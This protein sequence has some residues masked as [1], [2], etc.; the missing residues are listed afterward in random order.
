MPMARELTIGVL[1]GLGPEATVDFF[2]KVV[3]LTEAAG[4]QDHLHLII[5]NNHKVPNRNA[6]IARIGPS[7]GPALAA[8]ARRLERA[9]AD[10]LVMPCNA[11]HAFTAEIRAATGLPF[12]SII[13]ETLAELSRRAPAMERIGLLTA[14]GCRQARLYEQALEAAALRPV[15]TD[16]PQQARF[17]ELLYAIKAGRRE[18]AIAGRMRELG[19][20]LIAAGAE[21]V[22]AGCT[23]VPLVL[24]EGDLSRPLIDSTAVLA[25]ATVAYGK[26]RRALPGALA[27]V[28]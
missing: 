7:P 20:E 15:T 26:R 4:D 11:A 19:E 21:A 14:A 8:M 16:G 23:E 12:I 28:D 17:M 13:D 9:G 6:A 27:A 24:G 1:G 10:L 18:T 3:A 25:A 2:A 22:I 5:D